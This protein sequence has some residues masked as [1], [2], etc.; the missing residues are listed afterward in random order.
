KTD[1][2]GA[3]RTV[4]KNGLGKFDL[5]TFQGHF[6]FV[7]ARQHPTSGAGSGSTYS[8]DHRPGVRTQLG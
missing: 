8:S 1:G 3:V 6:S 5:W 7:L 2:A 4:V